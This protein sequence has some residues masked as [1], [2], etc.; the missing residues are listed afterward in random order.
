MPV[1]NLLKPSVLV[2][3][4][5]D[6]AN[7]IYDRRTREPIGDSQ[8]ITYS[9]KAQRTNVHR[10]VPQFE[11]IGVNEQIRGWFLVR[12]R[13][14][15]R[16]GW[17]PRRGDRIIKFGNWDEEV[18]IVNTEPQG[19]YRLGPTLMRLYFSDRRPAAANPNK[20]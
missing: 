14:L 3:E 11:Q 8:Y 19:H 18:Y 13:D 16:V 15:R 7:T 9:I 4:S 2:V 17:T 10:Q 6:K 5:I 1:P 12:T 20:G